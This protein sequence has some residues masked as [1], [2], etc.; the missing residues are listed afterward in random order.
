M[1][2]AAPEAHEGLTATAHVRA[3]VDAA[4]SRAHDQAPY[5]LCTP[6]RSGSAARGPRAGRLLLAS[7]C[8]LGAALL[9]GSSSALAVPTQFGERGTGA[10]QFIE[11]SGIAVF[12]ETGDVYVVDGSNQRVDSFSSE[13][14]FRFA[15]G[16]GVLDGK[17]E[18][19]LCSAGCQAGLPG[20]G[21]GQFSQPNGVAVDNDPTSESYGDFYVVDSGNHRV[22]KFDSSGHFLLTFGKGVN[23]NTK[24]DICSGAESENCGEGQFGFEPGEL[25]I[26]SS[27]AVDAAGTVYVG[28]F[29]RVEKFDPEGGF[30]SQWPVGEGSGLVPSLAVNAS[31][32]VLVIGEGIVGVH[33]YDQFGTEVGAPFDTEGFPHALTLGP[34]GE[35]YVDDHQD[36]ET[37]QPH[38]SEYDS[39]GAE[40]KSFDIGAEG[41]SRGI[42]F[43]DAIERVYLLNREA[44]RLVAVPPPGP[45][46]APGSEALVEAKPSHA[47]VE[48][49]I[50]AEGSPTK[51]RFEYGET[52]A[53]GAATSPT[54]LSEEKGL[55]AAVSA[56][57][58]LADLK[59]DTLYHF[60]AVAEDENG[61]TTFGPD[62]TLTTTPPA[63]ISG[64]STTQVTPESARLNVEINPQGA[65]TTYHFEYGLNADYEHSVPV[66]DAGA[67][68]DEVSASH[69]IV[70]ED[71]E[72]GTVYHYRVAATNIFG[73]VHGPDR[74]FTT[75]TPAPNNE[76]LADG[77]V[78]EMVS[79][80]N[81]HGASLEAISEEGGLIQSSA[82]GDGLAYFGTGPLGSEAEPE[83]SE[84]IAD[85]QFVAKRRAPGEWETRDITPPRDRPTGF[86]PGRRAEYLFFSSDLSRGF[87]EPLGE[88]PLAPEA[89]ERTPYLR[90]VT[91][92]YTP[93]ITPNDVP[94]GAKFGGEEVG[95][96][97]Y[98]GGVHLVGASADLSSAAV[99]SPV[100]LTDDFTTP[101]GNLDSVYRWS[102]GTGDLQLVSWIPASAEAAQEKSAA[103]TGDKAALGRHDDVVRHAVSSDGN[104]LIYETAGPSS[105]EHLFLRDMRLGK[106]VQLDLH[107]GGTDGG[108][109]AQFQDASADGRVVFFT[110]AERLT[111][112][113]TGDQNLGLADLYRCDL[114]EVAGGLRCRL[115]L[116]SVPGGAGEASDVLGNIVGTDE[117]GDRVYFVANG[118]L[119]AGAVHGD[120]PRDEPAEGSATAG[121]PAADTSCN[122]Y[123]HDSATGETRLV[124]VLSGRDFPDWGL[125]DAENLMW[126]TARVSPNG[127]YLAFMSQRSL[128]GY[129]NR[130]A[131]S[132]VPDEEVF[133][134]DFDAR[135]L[136][137]VS[138][139]RTSARPNGVF[140]S[141]DFPGLLVDRPQIW[142][143]QWVAAAVPGWTSVGKSGPPVRAPYQSDYLT[144]DGR[145]FFNSSDNLVPADVNGQFDVY[146]Y[147]QRAVGSCGSQTGC[148]AL[149]SSGQDA[150]ESAFLDAGDEGEDVFLLTAAKLSPN[151]AD[152]LN[153]VYDAHVCT[154]A[155]DCPAPAG[156]APPPCA[157]SDACRPA[158]APQPDIF[159]AP[160]SSTFSGAGN[161]TPPGAS[162]AL[163]R[164]RLTRA[165]LLAR[166]LKACHKDKAKKKRVSCERKV[167]RKYAPRKSMRPKGQRARRARSKEKGGRR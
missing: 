149:M 99:I 162:A 140:D 33:R 107:E 114:Q 109:L 73:T 1:Q 132:G 137:C 46:I 88:T 113:A 127:R 28:D 12:Q 2:S 119:A 38:L 80:P 130:D 147:E 151:D 70:I 87:V 159:G 125:K 5:G 86:H 108:G 8:L 74:E 7:L 156:G 48:A 102:A 163:K 152:A 4:P 68:S 91:G 106:S 35:V 141:G 75:S 53:Y 6:R 116:L 139:D 62:A 126:L 81:K 122:L 123:V 56:S 55:F 43:G 85:S 78:W 144:N 39:A 165:Q 61:H 136:N 32:E 110:D 115:T 41:G 118:R 138:C 15:V 121:L 49:T 131:R 146:E 160:A 34:A 100:A 24:G 93:L 60:R 82:S 20:A 3:D 135:Q 79:P 167:R 13:G 26:A 154:S 128:T 52:E 47:E 44:V 166:A 22:Q 155:S 42:A 69:S 51:Y 18:L 104:R 117:S 77:R 21:A 112:D 50:N 36:G 105:E 164:K 14:A 17:N 134:Y 45:L 27:V 120:C 54:P 133:S 142:R 157:T 64:E 25:S 158:P 145:V 153:D 92:D 129:D 98:V 95:G 84:N 30:L 66:P 9:A 89:T 37:E 111:K 101:E 23:L 29:G 67:G 71:L 40:L 63:L 161:L 143:G 124:A 11:P 59:P 94:S 83:G 97:D 90:D 96:G 148:V 19:E 57:A 58:D 16:W 103:T 31:G 72:P 150:G 76:P 10:G 65:E